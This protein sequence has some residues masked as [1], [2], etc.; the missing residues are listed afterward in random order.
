MCTIRG[1]PQMGCVEK[2]GKTRVIL[3]IKSDI[4]IER[5]ERTK[6][7]MTKTFPTLGE[8]P[9]YCGSDFRSQRQ[10]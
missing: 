7:T 1:Y 6:T 3:Y 10:S 5:R 4:D 9:I 2:F 8:L